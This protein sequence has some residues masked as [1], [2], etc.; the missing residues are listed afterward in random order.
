M[1]KSDRTWRPELPR[2]PAPPWVWGLTL[3]LLAL[4]AAAILRFVVMP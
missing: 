4:A 3:V 1:R 2:E